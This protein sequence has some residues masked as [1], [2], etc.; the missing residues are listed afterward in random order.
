MI[1]R[2]LQSI[3]GEIYEPVCTTSRLISK[4]GEGVKQKKSMK[5]PLPL[6]VQKE[7]VLN[8]KPKRS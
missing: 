7:L 8:D 6:V 3:V 2:D 4:S 1:P 5:S